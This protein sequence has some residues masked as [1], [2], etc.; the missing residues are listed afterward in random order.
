[1]RVLWQKKRR[2]STRLSEG[3]PKPPALNP[4]SAKLVHGVV[5]TTRLEGGITGK[6]LLVI[7]THVGARHVLVL[8]TGDAETDFLAL[9]FSHITQH[10]FIAE[11]IPGQRIGGQR[12]SVLSRQRDQVM[13]NS[14]YACRVGLEGAN[15][16]VCIG[17]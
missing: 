15:S 6:V 12:G 8:D 1:M 5:F 10:A 11:I 9:D 13:E 16:V 4:N 3:W 14:R 17:P 7:V 2:V